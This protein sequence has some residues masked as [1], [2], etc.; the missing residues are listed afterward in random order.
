MMKIRINASAQTRRL[1]RWI[2]TE[3]MQLLMDILRSTNKLY[4]LCKKEN[5]AILRTPTREE[6]PGRKNRI[7]GAV[8]NTS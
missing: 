3:G 4:R 5:A 7:P 1:A 6:L 2:V 8:I